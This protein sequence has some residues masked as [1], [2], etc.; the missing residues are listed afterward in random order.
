MYT[1]VTKLT[2][3]KKLTLAFLWR[4]LE[5]YDGTVSSWEADDGA[6]SSFSD[7]ILLVIR[8]KFVRQ[9]V[10]K[11]ERVSEIIFMF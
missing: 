6:I 3:M 1:N 4:A 10:V 9:L 11:S 5:T 2:N 7:E 8:K